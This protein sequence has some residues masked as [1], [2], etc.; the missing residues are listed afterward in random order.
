M[1]KKS[2]CCDLKLLETTD[3]DTFAVLLNS[4]PMLHPQ[5]PSTPPLLELDGFMTQIA[6]IRLAV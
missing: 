2:E 6:T 4:M 1:E 3:C 5:H